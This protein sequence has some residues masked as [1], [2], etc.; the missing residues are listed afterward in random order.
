MKKLTLLFVFAALSV[1]GFS[2]SRA[3]LLKTALLNANA[4]DTFLLRDS[5]MC[6]FSGDPDS[7][8]I[9]FGDM[10]RGNFITKDD[11]AF[12][13]QQLAKNNHTVWT[14]DSIAGAVVL[15]STTLPSSAL[16]AKKATKAWKGYF[17]LHKNGFFEAG[18]PLLSKDGN[19][20]IMYTA[21]QCGANCGNGGATLFQ[22]KNGKWV[23]VKNIYSWRK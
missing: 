3:L 6:Y 18:K 17:E 14:K 13:K 2:Q 8:S 22:F 7:D 11:V 5:V 21:F 1:A 10:V 23:S 19:T 9:F 12:M 16:S 20:A 4:S 15:S